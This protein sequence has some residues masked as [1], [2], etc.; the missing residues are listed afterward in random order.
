MMGGI[1]VPRSIC[2]N[3]RGRHI[4]T[5]M[6]FVLDGGDFHPS[7]DKLP[8]STV[9]AGDFRLRFELLGNEVSVAGPR[10]D[11]TL[12]LTAGDYIVRVTPGPALFDGKSLPWSATQM[13]GGCTGRLAYAIKESRDQSRSI[14]SRRR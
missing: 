7:L 1:S 6:S 12:E 13:K 4:L 2:N 3:Q 5:A 9:G 8:A 14:G 11:G 10:D